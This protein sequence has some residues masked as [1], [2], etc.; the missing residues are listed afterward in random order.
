MQL[1]C[2]FWELVGQAAFRLTFED[3][4]VKMN[5][6]STRQWEREDTDLSLVLRG[7]VA[8][9]Y[10]SDNQANSA[11]EALSKQ[12]LDTCE[13]LTKFI[14]GALRTTYAVQSRSDGLLQLGLEGLGPLLT[15]RQYEDQKTST[16]FISQIIRAAVHSVRCVSHSM[17]VSA[18][19]EP[20]LKPCIP[21]FLF[22][23]GRRGGQLC[24]SYRPAELSVP[25]RCGGGGR[26]R[27]AAAQGGG[28]GKACR[29][30]H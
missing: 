6:A 25:P 20:W 30:P 5:G 4:F 2:S 1:G 16:A 11:W 3:S 24:Q 27:R 26:S 9:G 13:R 15:L 12:H 8:E 29:W 19:S 28:G 14:G 23:R 21:H 7:L 18:T 10:L 17:K 22:R